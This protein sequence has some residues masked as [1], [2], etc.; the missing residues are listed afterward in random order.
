MTPCDS[1]MRGKSG[2]MNQACKRNSVKQ[3]ETVGQMV[4][5]SLIYRPQSPTVVK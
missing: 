5:P 4:P 1:Q 2:R 3:N